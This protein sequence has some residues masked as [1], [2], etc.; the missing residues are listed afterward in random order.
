MTQ[1]KDLEE[2]FTEDFNQLTEDFDDPVLSLML[3]IKA[4]QSEETKDT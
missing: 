2:L 1:E 3:L 4:Q